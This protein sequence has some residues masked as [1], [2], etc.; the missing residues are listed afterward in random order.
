MIM[1]AIVMIP[2][3]NN[4]NDQVNDTNY[5]NDTNCVNDSDINKTTTPAPVLISV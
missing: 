2:I 3:H 1:I 5:V 4:G